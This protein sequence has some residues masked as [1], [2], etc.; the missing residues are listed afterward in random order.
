MF[1]CRCEHALYT[2]CVCVYMRVFMCVNVHI[3]VCVYVHDCVSLCVCVCECTRLNV[4]VCVNVQ[5]C[6]SMYVY[7]CVYVCLRECLYMS[8]RMCLYLCVYACVFACSLPLRNSQSP[9]KTSSA[10]L[11]HG[12]CYFTPDGHAGVVAAAGVPR[13]QEEVEW[14]PVRSAGEKTLITNQSQTAASLW[15]MKTDTQ[16]QRA[17]GGMVAT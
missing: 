1:V 13:R 3:C 11:C 2:L 17:T 16:T 6:V 14:A 7:E 15:G 9:F 10:P 8:A 12:Q 5:V 4:R